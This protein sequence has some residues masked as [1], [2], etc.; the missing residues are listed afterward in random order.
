MELSL[1]PEVHQNFVLDAPAGVSSQA[2]IL[3]RLEGRDTF[4]KADGPDG[5]QIILVAG[6]GVLNDDEKGHQP[7]IVL[8][9]HIPGLQI[10]QGAA[11]QL[12]PLL[13]RLQGPGEGASSSRQAKGKKQSVHNQINHWRQHCHNTSK[14][15][16]FPPGPSL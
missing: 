13:R 2:D 9:Q 16:I 10:P 4:N 11:L 15:P 14:L 3:I 8:H 6:L 7:Q 1:G 5:D 12:H